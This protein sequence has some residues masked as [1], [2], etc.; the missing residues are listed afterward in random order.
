MNERGAV[1]N[2]ANDVGSKL[3]NTKKT[4]LTFLINYFRINCALQIRL[5]VFECPAHY[6]IDCL[7]G[8]IRYFKMQERHIVT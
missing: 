7:V 8:L 5:V 4:V 6:E 3:N 2:R 1:T